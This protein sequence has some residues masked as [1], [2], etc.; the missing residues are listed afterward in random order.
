[1]DTEYDAD[2][3]II[4]NFKRNQEAVAQKEKAHKPIILNLKDT[5][6]VMHKIIG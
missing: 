1:M 3:I 4:D 2:A 6:A 5:L